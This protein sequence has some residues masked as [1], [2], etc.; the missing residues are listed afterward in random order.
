MKKVIFSILILFSSFSQAQSFN[1]EGD[2]KLQAG[3]NFYGYGTGI[4]ASYDYGLSNA[5]SIGFGGVFFNSGTYNSNFFLFGRGDFHLQE[6]LELPTELDLYLGAELGLLGNS[7]FG[8]GGHL[9]GRY[10][11]SKKGYGFIEVGNN[12]ALGIGFNL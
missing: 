4:K 9:G 8:I 7:G 1:G 5:F 10:N 2:Q 6:A 11:F 12:A 3:F